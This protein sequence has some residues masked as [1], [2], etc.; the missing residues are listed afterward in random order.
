M[1]NFTF[2]ADSITVAGKTFPAAYSITKTG[3]VMAFVT[4]PGA[5]DVQRVRF[6]Q[7]HPEYAAA[8]AAAQAE[9]AAHEAEA[10]KAAEV[11]TKAEPAAETVQQ[12]ETEQPAQD[13]PAP[14]EERETIPEGYTATTTAAGNII[15]VQRNE[16][17]AETVQPDEAQ[18]EQPAETVQQAETEQPATGPVKDFIGQTIT[19]N[20][21]RIYFDAEA[22]RTRVIFDAAPTAAALAVLEKAGFYFSKTMNSYNKK[23]TCKAHRAAVALSGELRALYA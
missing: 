12:A 22:S 18:Q 19:G 16:Y 10:A 20:G 5:T 21:W 11:A 2:T 15:A 13:A 17:A 23:L 14:A 7:D 4:V 3:A 1:S 8:L 9:K 6:P